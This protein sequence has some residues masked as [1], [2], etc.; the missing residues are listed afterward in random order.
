MKLTMCLF[1]VLR[2]AVPLLPSLDRREEKLQLQTSTGQRRLVP[3]Q[4]APQSGVTGGGMVP[5]VEIDI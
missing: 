5:S 3:P 2:G 4:S 1:F